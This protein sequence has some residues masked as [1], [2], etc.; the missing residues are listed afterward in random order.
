MKIIHRAS[1]NNFLTETKTV[2][3]IFLNMCLL[4]VL[5]GFCSGFLLW[6]NISIFTASMEINLKNNFKL[7]LHI[8]VSLLEGN[9]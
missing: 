8:F 7:C 4:K 9:M 6:Y 3:G 1:E 2:L 5:A